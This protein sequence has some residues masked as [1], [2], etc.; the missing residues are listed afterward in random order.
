MTKKGFCLASAIMEAYVEAG[1]D[2][3]RNE[4][5]RAGWEVW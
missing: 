5:E 4:L 2:A 1:R 3:E